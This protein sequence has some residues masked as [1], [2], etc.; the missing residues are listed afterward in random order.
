MKDDLRKLEF[1]LGILTVNMDETPTFRK[2]K[3]EWYHQDGAWM[4]EWLDDWI[5]KELGKTILPLC[6]KLGRLAL[7]DVDGQ[8]KGSEQ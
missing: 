5:D 8:L 6:C 3:R 2:R 4:K 1:N 7:E